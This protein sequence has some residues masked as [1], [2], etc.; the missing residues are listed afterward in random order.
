MPEESGGS[1]QLPAVGK[2]LPGLPN[3]ADFIIFEGFAGLNTRAN[4]FAIEDQQFYWCENFMPIGPNNLRAMWDNGP[5]IYIVPSGKVILSFFWF[6]LGSTKLCI[7]FHTD[8]GGQIFSGDSPYGV[9]A[10]YP[11]GSFGTGIYPP[12]CLQYSNKFLIIVTSTL[13]NG[14]FIIDSNYL[15]Y[16]TGSIAPIIIIESTGTGYTSLPT[17]TIYG[18]EGSG[19][20]VTGTVV[21]G[22]IVEIQATSPGSGYS[23]LDEPGIA[24]S[25]GGIDAKTAIVTATISGG[26][27]T[28]TTIVDGG[29]GYTSTASVEFRGG[30]GFGA[31][32]TVT[33][34]GGV[35][36]GV[37]VS[38]GGANYI[39]PPTI[40]IIDG[41]N[42]VAVAH[43]DMM[44]SGIRGYSVESFSG[45][46]WVTRG[47]SISFTSAGSVSDF[48]GNVPSTDG[49]LRVNWGSLKQSN[50][51]M[52]L[53]GDSSVNY[54]SGVQTSGSPPTTTFTNLNVD[55]QIGSY[56]PFTT[57]VYS[58]A[59]MIVNP[60][61]IYAIYGGAVEKVSNELDGLMGQSMPFDDTE[62]H[63]PSAG[64]VDMF[65]VRCF[66]TLLPIKD[67]SN[68]RKWRF[69]MWDGKKWWTA[70]QSKNVIFANSQEFS[71]T[72]YAYGT[73]G[74]TIFRLFNTSSSVLV[75]T[76]QSKFWAKPSYLYTKS[77]MIVYAL[78][79]N[80]LITGSLLLGGA[81]IVE[82]PDNTTSIPLTS[83]S[84]RGQK[85]T[86]F[87]KSLDR[88][89]IALGMQ[90]VTN[91]TDLTL[92][93]MT[94]LLQQQ[95]L[96]T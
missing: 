25:G 76:V 74:N 35:I 46:I 9:V 56:W 93:S 96:N 19:A 80:P 26:V 18:G 38:D 51:F 67:N 88:S 21:N 7:V 91:S 10:T 78:A 55:P 68:V 11:P 12:G 42:P 59:T 30:G 24:F 58:R 27:V 60:N 71:S 13:D 14:Y 49:F 69:L 47:P 2:P 52:Y 43:V 31:T 15:L 33:A 50:G 82:S 75:K 28:G 53:I 5:D 1:F 63:Q 22:N 6:N 29:M 57:Q 45:R 36:T 23:F 64:V 16:Q 3:N 66:Y 85:Y 89:G 40:F 95:A 86:L 8:G 94:L 70:T 44:P 61:G 34:S 54:I 39:Y 37:T 87:R 17:M 20:T 48:V 83:V 92:V 84:I 32:G 72:L 73:D 65:G 41:D 62:V 4:R 79:T 77:S 90:F 81:I